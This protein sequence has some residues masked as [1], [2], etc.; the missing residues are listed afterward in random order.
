MLGVK[1]IYKIAYEINGDIKVESI[2]CPV[3]LKDGQLCIGLDRIYRK[4]NTVYCGLGGFN[5]CIFL[6]ENYVKDV[7][8]IK[9]KFIKFCERCLK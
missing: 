8:S 7:E 1:K 2:H 5:C 6:S 4:F 9:R 3:K